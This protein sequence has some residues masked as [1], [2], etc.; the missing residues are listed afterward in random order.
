MVGLFSVLGAKT[1]GDGYVQGCEFDAYSWFVN[2]SKRIG[3]NHSLSLTATGA[4]QTH[5]KRYDELTIEEWDKQ[6]KINN[7]VGYRY[8]AAFGYDMNGNIMTGTSY[9][10][11][12]KPQISLNHVWEIDR[13][14][15]LSSSL[16]LSIGDGYGYRG[17]GA[18]Y[19]KLYGAANG[20]P[21]TNYRKVDGTFDFGALMEDNA[22]SNNGSIAA[23]AK[24]KN[25]HMWY[26]LLSTYSNQ[27]NDNFNLQGGIDLRYYNGGHK[28]EVADLLGGAYVVDTDRAS[29]P[30]KKDDIAW[31]NARLGVGDVVYRNFDSY[32]AQYGAF[33]QLEYTQDKLSV[34]VSGNVN[35][36]TNWRKDYFYADNEESPKKQKL[37]MVLRRSQL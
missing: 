2:I 18:S 23:L 17:V 35:A 11:Y 10:V 5:N 12:H 37:V 14:S 25:T 21:N 13:K 29:V 36:A 16:Y 26:G 27:L 6:K 30:Y 4:P 33:G 20:I 3:D 8:N 24:N 1:W 28:A 9:N 34:I 7:G 22:K 32:I 19:S 31:Q 15:S